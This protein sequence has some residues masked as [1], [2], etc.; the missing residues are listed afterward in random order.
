M[1]IKTLLFAAA[2]A[3]TGLAVHAEDITLGVP[4]MPNAAVPGSF[5]AGAGVTHLFA[6]AF[7]DTL[8]FTGA[9]GGLVSGNLVTIGFLDSN[10]I[11]FTSVSINGQS[12]ALSTAG[13]VGLATLSTIAVSGPLVLTVSGVA[14]PGATAGAAISAS[15]AGTL[16][17]SPVPEPGSGALLFAGLGI[18]ALLR[19]R[20]ST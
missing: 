16:N 12:F 6:G 8:T 2:L 20:M 14:S 5:S 18:V 19:R 7:T 11:D 9:S 15:Y 10:N 4:L 1:Q 13:G 17:V 3:S